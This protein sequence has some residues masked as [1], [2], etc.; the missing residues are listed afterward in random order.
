MSTASFGFHYR[1]GGSL[2]IVRHHNADDPGWQQRVIV[3]AII[4]LKK[5]RVANPREV[6]S[7]PD[8]EAHQVDARFSTNGAFTPVRINAPPPSLSSVSATWS[9]LMLGSHSTSA[10]DQSMT[11]TLLA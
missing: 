6:V 10:A 3:L 5:W 11:Q 2:P 7:V 4:I 8:R 9:S 1:Q